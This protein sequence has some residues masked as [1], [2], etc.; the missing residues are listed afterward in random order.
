M[1][2]RYSNKYWQVDSQC[3]KCEGVV[4]YRWQ[5]FFI[6]NI[7]IYIYKLI[8]NT[9]VS[10]SVVGWS[11]A[12]SWIAKAQISPQALL[13][14]F[15]SFCTFFFH[16]FFVESHLIFFFFFFFF[17]SLAHK[18]FGST[19]NSRN[20]KKKKNQSTKS[21]VPEVSRVNER[22]KM[23]IQVEIDPRRT[24]N[25][26]VYRVG[27]ADSAMRVEHQCADFFIA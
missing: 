27:R 8:Y 25:S 3:E 12:P 19:K 2:V 6:C 21:T 10:K 13:W 17:S 20:K 24:K 7:Y 18:N 14:R 22:A 1:K 23:Q 5:L 26:R 9:V 15:A 4:L 16:L 11:L